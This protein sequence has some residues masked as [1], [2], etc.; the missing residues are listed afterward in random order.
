MTHTANATPARPALPAGFTLRPYAGEADV[1]T[2]V[3]IR[4]AELEADRI[5]ARATVG[6]M[7]AAFSHPSK[8]FDPARDLSF[9]EL[10]GR[11]VA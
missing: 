9:V 4:N 2:Y 5:P 1:A 10:D 8:Y 6:D 3:R 7:T 11:A